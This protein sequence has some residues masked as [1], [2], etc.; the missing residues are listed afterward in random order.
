MNV[1][2]SCCADHF[3]EITDDPNKLQYIIDLA[4]YYGQLYK[5]K[6]NPSKTKIVISGPTIDHNYYHDV[7]PWSMYGQTVT[8]TTDIQHLR[9]VISGS[10]QI[11]TNVAQENPFL[12]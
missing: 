9:Q 2:V 3:M 8:V 12:A 7:N 11:E 5:V 6:Y 10:Q 4:A 1:G